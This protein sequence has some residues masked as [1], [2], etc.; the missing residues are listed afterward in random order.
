MRL[1][2]HRTGALRATMATTLA[3]AIATGV[4]SAEAS[5][6]PSHAASGP[7]AYDSLSLGPAAPL[8]PIQPHTPGTDD[9]Y[10]LAGGCFVVYSPAAREVLSLIHI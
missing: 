1:G 8:S 2:M 5:A 6:D 10:D 7:R 9:R 4:L 3:A